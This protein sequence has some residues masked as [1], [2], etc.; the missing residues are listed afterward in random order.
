MEWSQDHHLPGSHCFL[1]TQRAALLCTW[2]THAASGLVTWKVFENRGEDQAALAA[3]TVL[4]D[5][6][7][8]P[9]TVHKTSEAEQRLHGSLL[10]D[11]YASRVTHWRY[12][13]RSKVC[14]VPYM[15]KRKI[16]ER[17]YVF[18]RG[19]VNCS[20]APQMP[21]VRMPSKPP[22]TVGEEAASRRIHTVQKTE[23]FLLFPLE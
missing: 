22:C 20:L 11:S 10:Q 2:S 6:W 19:F 9:S 4:S 23:S 7:Q 8:V 5:L 15:L 12:I 3:R 1:S 21:F 17:E 13:H 14:F 18:H 16:T